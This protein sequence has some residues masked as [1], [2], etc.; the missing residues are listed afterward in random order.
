MAMSLVASEA[1]HAAAKPQPAVTPTA[2][3]VS[4]E[5]RAAPIWKRALPAAAN[6]GPR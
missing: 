6:D 2:C 1:A 3:E 5:R 4:I